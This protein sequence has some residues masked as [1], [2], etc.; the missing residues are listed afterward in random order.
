MTGASLTT[1]QPARTAKVRMPHWDN[2]RFLAVTLVVIGHGIQRMTYDSN[3]ALALYLFIYA[4]HMPAFAIISGYFSKPGAPTALQMRRVITDIIV[5]Y[6]IMETIWTLVKFLVEGKTDLNPSTPSWTLWFLLALGIFRLI[7]PYLSQVRWPL[8]WAVIASI[9]V[10][11]LDNVDSTFSLS[12]AIGILPFFVLGWKLREWGLM[13]RWN[14]AERLVVLLRALAVTVFA[15]FMAVILGNIELW[16]TIDL[17][18]WFFY[19]ASYHGLGED[20]W[21]AGGVRLGLIVLAVILSAA[22][23][24]LVPRRHT[25]VTDAGQATMYVYLLHSFVLYPLRE[26]GLLLDERASAMWLVSMILGSI[27]IALVLSMPIV[28]KIF[29]PLIEPK[30]NWVFVPL[31]K[32]TDLSTQKR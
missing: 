9:G 12:R 4:F 31:P 32:E 11:Y 30:P 21:W 29:R 17:R 28:K 16:R 25:W 6:F 18:F 24:A 14:V 20:Q 8:L 7:L 10:G 3:Y 19:D 26:S 1:P 27:G 22:F 13:D 2:A 5:P 15:G 23:F